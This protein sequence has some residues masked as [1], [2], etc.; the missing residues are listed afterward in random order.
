MG[1]DSRYLESEEVE[2]LDFPVFL[3]AVHDETRWC[4]S[5]TLTLTDLDQN[6][7]PCSDSLA[8]ALS[9]KHFFYIFT[10]TLESGALPTDLLPR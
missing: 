6:W 7:L 10:V 5:E 8:A 3:S 9:N 2:N 1:H 4:E